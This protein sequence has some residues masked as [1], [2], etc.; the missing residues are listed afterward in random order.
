MT[1]AKLRAE[2]KGVSSLERPASPAA[3]KQ[4][5]CE[6]TMRLC[7][8]RYSSGLRAVV[9]TGSLA[10]E[11][12][13]C[14]KENGGWAL[15]SDAEFLL[16]FHSGAPLPLLGEQDA[17]RQA[18]ERRLEEI[19]I[20]CHLLLSACY[21][22]YL[23][24]L[25]PHIFASELKACG[26]VVWGDSEV[27]FHIPRFS[28]SDIPLEDA[29]RLLCNRM[30]EHLGVAAALPHRPA[31]PPQGLHYHTVKL[32][33]DMATS[34]LVFSGAYEP[35]YRRRAMRL[36][37][38][39]ANTASELQWPFPP[40]PFVERVSACTDWKLG[41][42][43]PTDGLRSGK[44]AA[45][46]WPFW[47]E[48]IA[49][50]HHLWRWELIR[51]TDSAESVSD[52]RLLQIWTQRQ[53]RAQRLRGWLYV[54]R[55]Q[56][57]LRSGRQWPRWGCRAWQVSPRYGIYGAASELFPRLPFL[58]RPTDEA[59]RA[60]DGELNWQ[61][62]RSWLPVVRPLT[63]SRAPSWQEVALE[64]SWNYE[65]FVVDTRS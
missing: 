29:W 30:V 8:E 35:T 2:T 43:D 57:W 9:L 21:P 20:R 28:A 37:Q 53:P 22:E 34:F 48:A 38:L 3:F 27:L 45:Q 33:L 47:E 12:G 32:C 11:E 39:A 50:M 1:I 42:A 13:T 61:E 55:R 51:L 7:V 10:R 63:G 17:L 25:G 56:G 6:E 5:I 59:N 52:R 49:C 46:G 31:T 36:R 18:V 41:A 26:Q 14:V 62:L 24:K 15:L 54:V 40:G 23:A 64:I 60:A 58:L 65:E 44:N 4:A 19:G 16:V